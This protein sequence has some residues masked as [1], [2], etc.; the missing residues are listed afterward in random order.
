MRLSK[1]RTALAVAL[2]WAGTCGTAAAG[3]G[4]GLSWG[5]WD[6][7]RVA[8]A[9]AA[10]ARSQGL[11][12]WEARQAAAFEAAVRRAARDAER[13]VAEARAAQA[14]SG[15]ATAQGNDSASA[16]PGTSGASGTS[17]SGGSGGSSGR[18]WGAEIA[19]ALATPHPRPESTPEV[20]PEHQQAVEDSMTEPVKE[21]TFAP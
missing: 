8:E 1:R 9:V 19:E 18:D 16:E 11:A 2:V 12:A 10:Q 15:V 4:S 13:A 21:L 6:R 20:D 14:G 5:T 3:S 17:G 7:P